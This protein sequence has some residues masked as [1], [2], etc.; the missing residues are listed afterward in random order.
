MI[1]DL[2]KVFGY[3]ELI[4]GIILLV[5]VISLG[6]YSFYNPRELPLIKNGLYF[7]SAYS[8]LLSSKQFLEQNNS[9]RKISPELEMTSFGSLYILS[10]V[11]EVGALIFICFLILF[12]ILSILLIMN[13]ILDIKGE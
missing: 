6:I 11:I 2:R 8:N 4:L 9:T 10:S 7:Q 1:E 5:G 3:V 12:F 13:G